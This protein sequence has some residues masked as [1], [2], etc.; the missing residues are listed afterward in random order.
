MYTGT[1]SIQLQVKKNK[2]M[3]SVHTRTHVL[4]SLW[5]RQAFVVRLSL[6]LWSF[7]PSLFL[8]LFSLMPVSPACS[9]CQL[10]LQGAADV[11]LEIMFVQGIFLG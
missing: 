5:K 11:P 6:L 10:K 9:G 1:F 2:K 3:F 4:S 7:F 8:I